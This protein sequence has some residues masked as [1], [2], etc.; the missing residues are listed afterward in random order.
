M[1]MFKELLALYWWV[2]VGWLLEAVG[3]VIKR[4]G[5]QLEEVGGR[6]RG[7]R[8]VVIKSESNIEAAERVVVKAE[9]NIE[10]AE[11]VV[12]K[13]ESNIKAVERVVVKAESNIE[14]AERV[15]VIAPG[16]SILVKSAT[17]EVEEASVICVKK[18][19]RSSQR[20]RGRGRGVTRGGRT[21]LVTTGW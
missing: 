21:P 14:T 16:E 10:A 20:S 15:V 5:Q 1:S 2:I 8:V 6:C 3:A 9:S 12:V 13:A 4:F 17:E 18:P 19:A 11:R 7:R